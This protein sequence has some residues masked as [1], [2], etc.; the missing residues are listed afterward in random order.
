MLKGYVNKIIPFSAV[1]GPGNRTAIFLQGCNMNCL[2]CHNPETIEIASEKNPIK[3]VSLMSVDEV[4]EEVKKVRP[5]ITGVTTSGGECTL[6]MDFLRELFTEVRKLGL[7]SFI[8][9]NGFIALEGK[10]DFLDT[11]DKAMVDCKSFD[12]EEHKKLTGLDNKTVIENI[13][14]LGS[15]GKLFEVRTVIVPE[16]LDNEYNVDNISKLIASID[17]NIRYKIIKYRPMGIREDLIHKKMPSNKDMA[18]LYAIAHKNGLK[19][20]VII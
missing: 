5:F 18:K 6:Q 7:T 9:T 1:D 4:M 2:Y 14:Y 15:I 19:D 12:P 20:I 13:K 16:I 3:D 10:D 8:D 11:V 17:T